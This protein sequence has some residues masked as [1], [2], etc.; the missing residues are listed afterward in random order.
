MPL[1]T[2]RTALIAAGLAAAPRPAWARDL[3]RGR[4]THGVASGD[5]TQSDVVIWTRFVPT[6]QAYGEIAWEVASDESFTTVV[7]SGRALARATNDYCIKVDVGGLLP[8]RPYFYRFLGGE[9][10]SLTGMTRT[11]PRGRVRD[12]TLGLFSCSNYGFGYFHAYGH[13]A[14][15][16]D[17]E[18][19]LHVGDYI[20]EYGQGTYPSPAQAVPGRMVESANE[21]VTLQDYYARYQT[22]RADPDLQELHRL[23]PWA[24]VWDDHELTND[25]WSDGA[26]NHQPETEGDW[27]TRF[28]CAWKAY[29][30]WMPIRPPAL[31]AGALYRSLEWGDLAN[32]ALLDTRWVGRERPFEWEE[33]LAP[34]A[35]SGPAAQMAAIAAL[36]PRLRD[37]GRTIMGAEQE[38]WLNTELTRAADSRKSWT[39]LAQQLVFGTNLASPRVPQFLDPNASASTRQFVGLGGQLGAAGIEWNLD[40]WGGYPAARQRMIDAVMRTGVNALILGGDSHNCWMNNIP[41]GTDAGFA[42]VELAGSSV[43]SPGFESYLNQAPVGGREEA[44]R[45]ANP[46][47]VYC[48]ITN[49]GY[50]AV[51]LTRETAVGEVV[52]FSSVRDRP[53]PT[54]TS[55]RFAAESR[56][57]PGVGGW[58]PA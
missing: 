13:A 5:P 27:A 40:A 24:T 35:Q 21:I 10:P 42:M 39:V 3:P 4:F 48:D 54:P 56:R 17:I 7:A 15:R 30:D 8:G 43:T 47:L 52:Q 20:Y 12:M 16:E 32:I 19:V 45:A 37:P 55:V 31:P 6:L 44:M 41:A 33:V 53:R 25:A 18:L 36:Q 57:G 1:I 50:A 9:G 29:L 28:A 49:K 46:N 23:K 11:A 22:Y 2:R 51:T 14:A 34:V 58:E 26:Q 38:T